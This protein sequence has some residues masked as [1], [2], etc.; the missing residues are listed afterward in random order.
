MLRVVAHELVHHL[1]VGQRSRAQLATALQLR[2]DRERSHAEHRYDLV[3]STAPQ[4]S[5]EP[6]VS[7]G[8]RP[9]HD[10]QRTQ[11]S[12]SMRMLSSVSSTS[13][14]RAFTSDS[15]S[16]ATICTRHPM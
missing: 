6:L 9:G 5:C 13:A 12:T 15:F 10:T 11:T 8:H 1:Y 2:S 4:E 16:T 7:C 3:A 14:R